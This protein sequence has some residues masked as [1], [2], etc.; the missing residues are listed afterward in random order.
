MI[1]QIHLARRE[2]KAQLGRE[3]RRNSP[4]SWG[5]AVLLLFL[6]FWLFI[7]LWVGSATVPDVFFLNQD[8]KAQKILNQALQKENEQRIEQ[9]KS[10]KGG[11][12][13]LE[14]RARLELGMLKPGE[15]FYEVPN[16]S[17]NSN[18]TSN[19]ISTS[20]STSVSN[21][22]HNSVVQSAE[23]LK[24]ELPNSVTS[25]SGNSAANGSSHLSDN[26]LEDSFGNSGEPQ[27]PITE[28]IAI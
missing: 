28:S 18:S 20:I 1:E 17:A 25:Q 4:V 14:A 3:A 21:L 27:A 16:S 5:V 9:I 12:E 6:I 23:H 11:D 19:S 2:L 8:I 24:P 7:Q 13:E 15:V 26:P 10:L 22:P